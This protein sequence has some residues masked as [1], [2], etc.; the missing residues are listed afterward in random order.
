MVAFS[1]TLAAVSVVVPLLVLAVR[2]PERDRTT[3]I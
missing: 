1:L 2:V 3:V